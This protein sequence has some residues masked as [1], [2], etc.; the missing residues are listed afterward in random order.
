MKE[1][2]LIRDFV[3]FLEMLFFWPFALL[4]MLPLK[5]MDNILGTKMV[6]PLIRFM[7]YV[8]NL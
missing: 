1:T 2:G 4:V 6:Q 8:A 7:K 5:Y 3:T